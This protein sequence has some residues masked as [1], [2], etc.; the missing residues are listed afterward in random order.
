MDKDALAKS[1][2]QR[3]TI[4]LALECS[5]T[6]LPR[7]CDVLE[8]EQTPVLLRPEGR[9]SAVHHFMAKVHDAVNDTGIRHE[10]LVLLV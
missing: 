10:V 2:S 9:T 6:M 7:E 4:G 8:T 5:R 3:P 1:G